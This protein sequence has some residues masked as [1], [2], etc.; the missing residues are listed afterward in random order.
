[1][2][3]LKLGVNTYKHWMKIGYI[4]MPTQKRIESL[5]GGRFKSDLTIKRESERHGARAAIEKSN[6]K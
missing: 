1:M 5:T 6:Q 2:R 3:E 4:P